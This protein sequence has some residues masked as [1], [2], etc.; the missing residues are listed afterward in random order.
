MSPAAVYSALQ[1]AHRA[2]AERVPQQSQQATV[3]ALGDARLRSL[4]ERYVDAWERAD[5][6]AL[7]DLLTEDATITMPPYRTWFAGRDAVLTFLRKTPLRGV[8]WRVLPSTANGQLGFATYLISEETGRYEWHSMEVIGL[9]GDRI[10]DI[11]AFLDPDG[12]RLFDL[13]PILS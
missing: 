8:R 7:V 13:P 9:R 6:N 1:R 12:Y 3:A 2:V 10:A 5:V 11:T 4:V